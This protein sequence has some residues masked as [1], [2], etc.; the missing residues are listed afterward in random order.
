MRPT[1]WAPW[2][3][4]YILSDKPDGCI[5]CE[6]PDHGP[7]LQNYVL[8]VQ[9]RAFVVL[10]RYPYTNGH[11]MVVPR[12][13]VSRLGDLDAETMKDTALLL[14][15]TER[16]VREAIGPEGVN[17]GL[18][19]GRAAGAGI[20]AHLHWHLVPRWIGDGNY[21]AVVGETR[22]INQSL[23]DAWRLLRPHF[24]RLEKRQAAE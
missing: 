8:H 23:E 19:Q 4:D 10:N 7:G 22:V 13:H 9:E 14:Q 12:A 3:I 2:R 11:L 5:F 1:I 16:I 21:V 20:D 24:E 15:E 6:F 17:I 18:N